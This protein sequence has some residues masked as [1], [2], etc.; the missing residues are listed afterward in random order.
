MP[1]TNSSKKCSKCKNIKL[2]SEFH[3]HASYRDGLQY[4][5]KE[6]RREYAKADVGKPS[7]IKY[8]AKYAKSDAGKLSQAR[9]RKSDAGKLSYAKYNAANPIKRKAQNALTHAV[10]SGKITRSLV[11]EECPSTRRIE[12]HHN[13]YA[14]PLEVRWL[15]S[16]CHM[17]WHKENGPGLNG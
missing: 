4:N 3:R 1:K 6:C 5:C 8:A 10:E 17:A 15:C 2:L 7:K 16:I 14:L 13:D 12:A 11:C 9:Y